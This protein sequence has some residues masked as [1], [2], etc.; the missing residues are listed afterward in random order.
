MILPT[1]ARFAR[2]KGINLLSMSDWTHPLWLKEC[3][4]QLEE[5][6]DGL[7]KLKNQIANSKNDRDILFLL[8]VEIA[9]IYSQDG[10]VRRI[11]NLV[12]APNMKIAEKINKELQKRGAN[13]SSDGRPII[14][15]SSRSL[16]ELIMSISER[17]ML[18][19]AH[20]WTPHFGVYGSASG[21]D[22]LHEAYGDFSDYIYGVETGLSS[23]PEMNWQM[24]ELKNKSILSFSDAHSPAKMGREATV[25]ELSEASYDNVRKA[26]KR[27]KVRS[28]EFIVHSKNNKNVSMNNEPSTMNRIIYTLEFYPEEGKYHFSGHRKCKIVKSAEEIRESGNTCPVCNKRLTE[29]V[30]YRIEQL[31]QKLPTIVETKKNSQGLKWYVDPTKQH[32]PYVK[33]VPLIEIIAESLH[34]TPQSQKVKSVFETLTSQLDSEI[35]ILLKTPIKEIEKIAGTHIAQGVSIVRSGSIAITPGYDGVYGVVKI[36]GD[37]EE[38]K[39]TDKK[40]SPQLGFE[41]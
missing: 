33:L 23:D 37:K 9:S 24:R 32:P 34:S 5:A 25:F 31:G 19:P 17:A 10:Q 39:K 30:L 1:M 27:E 3:A 12:F 22:S 13:L 11:H 38:K 15:L 40:D 16:L 2:Q 36:W 41:I 29:G 26:I 35:Q 7:Y 18:I 14:G 6:A 20:V 28:S 8:S 21:F 4:S